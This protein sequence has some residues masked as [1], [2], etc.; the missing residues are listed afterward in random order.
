MEYLVRQLFITPVLWAAL[1]TEPGSR[2]MWV[3]CQQQEVH[4][5]NSFD[6]ICFPNYISIGNNANFMQARRSEDRFSISG[7]KSN[8][9]PARE[10][11]SG[12][13]RALEIL[14]MSPCRRYARSRVVQ[15]DEVCLSMTDRQTGSCV[16]RCICGSPNNQILH[17][18][19]NPTCYGHW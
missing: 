4:A 1:P 7:F 13:K 6:L 14:P 19:L 17:P 18:P 8:G 2:R 9:E 12:L 11:P 3:E 5:W 16:A 10:D 15:S